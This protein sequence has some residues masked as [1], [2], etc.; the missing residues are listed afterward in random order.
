[1]IASRQV[2]GALILLSVCSAAAAQEGPAGVVTDI[3][4]VREVAETVPVLGEL[5]ANRES[6]VAARVAG[7]VDAVPVRPGDM[8]AKGQVLARLDTE[9]LEIERA[10][11]E[12]A[13]AEARAGKAIADALVLNARRGFERVDALRGSAAFSQGVAD[14]REGALAEA[15]GQQSQAQ[16]RI[17]AAEAALARA[18]YSLE[19][20]SV[21]APFSGIVLGV[22]TER[23]E[24]ITLG[25]EILRLLDIG[26][27]EVEANVPATYMGALEIGQPIA[28]RTEDGAGI[29]LSVRAFLPVEFASTRTRPVRLAADLADFDGPVAVGQSVSVDIPVS[30][31]RRTLTVPKDALVQAG[32]GWRVFVHEDGKAV[33]RDVEIG[34]ALG[35][36]FEVISGL[37]EGDEVVVRGNERLRP[38]QEIAPSRAELQGPA[39][40]RR[41]DVRE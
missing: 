19:R 22:S 12:A 29:D 10:E 25:A 6:A 16:A 13:R 11:A 5:V 14:D 33:P 2:A 36:R 15:M 18:G 41:A 40:E 4:D 3:V 30:A 7:V 8:V 34:T 37:A 9:L 39:A 32:T 27:L 1:V 26:S 28:G 35:E 38:M 24:Y 17:L 21:T 31:A 23:G 20:A